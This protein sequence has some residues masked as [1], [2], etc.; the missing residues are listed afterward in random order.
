MQISAWPM[1]TQLPEPRRIVAPDPHMWP[2]TS[3]P[4]LPITRSSYVRES[5]SNSTEAWQR[6]MFR[7]SPIIAWSPCAHGLECGGPRPSVNGRCVA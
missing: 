5:G 1:R 7:S 6:E 3:A 4:P 2:S